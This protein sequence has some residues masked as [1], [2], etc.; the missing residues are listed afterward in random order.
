MTNEVKNQDLKRRIVVS[1]KMTNWVKNQDL[2]AKM[3]N[4]VKKNWG[5]KSI[6][7]KQIRLYG[8]S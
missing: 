8:S 4:L 3:T 5:L 2:N 7:Y 1:A 6:F